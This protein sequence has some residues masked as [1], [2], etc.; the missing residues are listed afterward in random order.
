MAGKVDP[1][2]DEMTVGEASAFW[3]DHS[4]ADYPSHIVELSYEPDERV[5]VVAIA[6]EVAA[7]LERRAQENGVSVET[8]VNIWVQEKLF[9]P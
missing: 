6:A 8:L 7:R 5:T 3:N 4:V 2:P 1:I 9:S